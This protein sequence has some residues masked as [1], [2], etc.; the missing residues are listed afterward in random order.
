VEH[1]K[2]GL[3][4]SG[5]HEELAGCMARLVENQQ[6]ARELGENGWHKAKEEY[7]TE[8]CARKVYKVLE[9]IKERD[10]PA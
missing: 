6:W 4:Y 3:L 5:S 7:T 2:T 9:E 10:K 8:A 1:E